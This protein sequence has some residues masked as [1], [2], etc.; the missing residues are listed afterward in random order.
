MAVIIREA[1]PADVPVVLELIRELA[2]YE[3]EPDAVEATPA[4]LH[5]ALFG[6]TANAA[7][8]LA[9][10]DGAVVGCAI[11]FFN[12][13]TWTGRR[14]IYLED[15][16]VRPSARGTGA[17][18]A[19]I[20]ELARRAIHAGCARLDWAVLDW[21]ESAIGFYEALGAR[22]MSDW[23]IYRLTRPNLESLARDADI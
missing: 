18:R 15:L 9:E 22:R 7:G 20:A 2:A 21:N 23:L 17:G 1:L 10:R 6:P 11:Y 8:L 12:F 13:S 16:Y 4:M 14:G 5:A 19:L 3:R